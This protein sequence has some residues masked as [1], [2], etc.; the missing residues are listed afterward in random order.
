M[1]AR[2]ARKF[3]VLHLED[4]N[5]HPP[6][7]VQKAVKALAGSPEMLQDYERQ[8]AL[9][10]RGRKLLTE[11]HIPEQVEKSLAAVVEA[12]PSRR[13]HPRDPAILAA[14]LG[15]LLLV[16]LLVWNFLGRPAV[17]PPDA[18]EIAEAVIEIDDEPYEPVGEPA[19]EV[20]DWFLMKGF[21]N[22][23]VPEHL[24]A[25]PAESGGL[26]Q[27]QNQP[28]AVVTVPGRNARF[29]V[30]EAA[31]FGIDI[32]AGEWRS[33]RIDANHAA[34]IRQL[35]GMCFMILRKGSLA[36]VQD[37]LGAAPR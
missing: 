15:F 11:A 27:I 29:I 30:F 34:A 24:E 22:F 5:E 9:D 10:K 7:P 14:A 12:I 2:A 23:K 8:T 28:V 1:N 32:P 6:A 26:L 31:P 37:L 18:A 16:V 17:F 36:A 4:P 25:H 33:A 21:E 3:L 20:E 13:L 35:D 19:G